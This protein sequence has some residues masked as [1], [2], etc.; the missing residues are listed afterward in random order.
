MNAYIYCA[1]IYCE[2]CGQEISPNAR[3]AGS[4]MTATAT[5]TR[6]ARMGTVAG[7]PIARSIAA[8]AMRSWKIR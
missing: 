4:L 8:A 3:R 6:K 1:D 5:R 2:G 7:K